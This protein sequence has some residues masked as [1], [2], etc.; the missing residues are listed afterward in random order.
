MQEF[1]SSLRLLAVAACLLPIVFSSC[2]DASAVPEEP[3]TVSP[4][5]AAPPDVQDPGPT[6]TDPLVVF[7]GDSISAGLH[8]D[9]EDAFPAVVQ[10]ALLASGTPFRMVNA[11]ISGDTSAGGLRRIDWLLKQSPDWVVI[12][13]GGNDGLRGMDLEAIEVNLRGI[14]ER[15]QTAGAGVILCGMVLPPNYGKDYVGGFRALYRELSEELDTV[16]VPDFLVGIG[17]D[18]ELMMPDGIHPNERGHARLAEKLGPVLEGVL[19]A[20]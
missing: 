3:V 20:E 9:P 4:T 1:R 8:V 15:V 14:V 17:G 2:G 5:P 18:P 13:L 19:S 11:G 6:E 16:L 10:E 12:E 7:L